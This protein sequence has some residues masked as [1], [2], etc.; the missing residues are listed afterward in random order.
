[1]KKFFHLLSKPEEMSNEACAV[2][3]LS[4]F[5]FLALMFCWAI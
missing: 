5:T 4:I 3:M 1:M 2:C